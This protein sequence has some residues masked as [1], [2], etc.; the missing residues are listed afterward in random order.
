MS[1]LAP[2]TLHQGNAET[3]SISITRSDSTDD[4]TLITSLRLV[5]KPDRCTSDASTTATVLTTANPAQMVIV[6][7]TAALIT[8]EAYI[9]ASALVDPY[10]RW[11]H[12]D[13]FVGLLYRTALYGPVTVI[14]L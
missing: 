12:V 3:I 4:L 10:N 9:P 7:Q 13:A 1:A 6:S 2:I 5:M 11:W 8:A 14:D